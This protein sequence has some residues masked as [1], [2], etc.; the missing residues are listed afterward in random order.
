[1]LK[2]LVPFYRSSPNKVLFCHAFYDIYKKAAVQ[3]TYN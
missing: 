3:L 2:Y 1:M